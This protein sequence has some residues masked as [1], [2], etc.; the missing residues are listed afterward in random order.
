MPLN[1]RITD[2]KGRVV[3]LVGASTGIGRAT[4]ALLHAQGA[5]VIVSARNATALQLFETAHAGSLGLAFVATDR[6]GFARAAQVIVA[7]YGRIDLALYCAGY[8][9]AMRATQFDLSEALR[10][11]E[12]NY[13]GALHMLDAVLPVLL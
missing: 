2:W 5:Q 8:Y 4:A 1:P 6:A 12:V 11:Q 13:V 10:H 3:W 9:K 7:K